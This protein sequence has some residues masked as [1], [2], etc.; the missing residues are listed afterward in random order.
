MHKNLLVCVDNSLESTVAIDLS[1][2][3]ASSAGSLLT[4]LHVYA[5]KLH[6]ERFSQMEETLPA[7]Y[8]V[9]EELERQRDIH[10]SLI[11]KGLEI[12]SDSYMSVLKARCE[13]DGL[14]ATLKNREGK[15]Y[16]EIMRELE[17]GKYD[18]LLMGSIGL[19]KV[20]KSRIGSVCERTAR[21]T[22]VDTFIV[23]QGGAKGKTILV[24]I[25]GSSNS[26][27]ALKAAISIASILGLEVEAISAFDADYHHVAFK[28]I[29]TVL[30]EEGGKIFK[31]KE[32]EK[33]HS[34]IIDENLAALYKKHLERARLFAEGFG[35]RIKT[36]LLQ[37]K[38]FEAILSYAEEIKPF[39]IAL[40]KRGVHS[41]STLDI[42]NATENVLREAACSVLISTQLVSPP[43][44]EGTSIKWSIEA[45]ELLEK[46][47][48]FVR[49]MVKSMVDEEAKK[50]N[51]ETV[52]EELMKK[53]RSRYGL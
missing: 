24:A 22:I 33:L 2:R 35:R 41:S 49:G 17:E 52:T 51:V 42:G 3:L 53:V 29:S 44:P 31:F 15:N 27:G 46:I 21:R 25:D 23:K 18:L 48:S 7:K 28:S 47:P 26:F 12:V 20:K 1:A 4:G 8:Q 6:S 19:G 14:T 36:T 38:P 50:S 13:K 40:G 34:E 43:A 37:G 45:I 16:E 30:S 10:S 5:A 11:T 39:A 32:Q 9:K